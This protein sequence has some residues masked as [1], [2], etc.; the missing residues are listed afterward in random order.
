MRWRSSPRRATPTSSASRR[1][2]ATR[3][4]NGRRTT[5]SSS[6][7]CSASTSPCTRGARSRC[8]VPGPR[9]S[10]L[11]RRPR[12]ERAGRRRPAG[13]DHTTRR[14]RCGVVHRRHLPVDRR[15]LAGPGRAADQHR[16][17]PALRAGH[18]RTDRRDLVDG[19][20]HL[21]QPHADRRVQHLGRSRGGRDRVQLRLPARDGR[22][23]RDPPVPGHARTDRAH[24]RPPGH[25]RQTSCRICSASSAPTISN[26][27]IP[28]HCVALPSTT[29]SPC[30]P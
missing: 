1:W 20:R 12:R 2:P 10:A 3:R 26:V 27:T 11:G 24:R 19:R 7:T 28:A 4:W 16:T 5:R 14:H 17:R 6:A 23:R 25:P 21:R 22:P 8:S 13:A 29:R 18:R 30:S 15:R 9:R